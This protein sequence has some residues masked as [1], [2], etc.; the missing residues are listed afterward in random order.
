[1]LPV[2]ITS[3]GGY[4]RTAAFIIYNRRHQGDESSRKGDVEVNVVS[5]VSNSK[6]TLTSPKRN[7]ETTSPYC[8]SILFAPYNHEDLT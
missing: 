5:S 3:R 7:T 1:M 6:S 2:A 8:S 4:G